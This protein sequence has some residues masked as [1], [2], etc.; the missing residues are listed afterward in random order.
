MPSTNLMLGIDLGTQSTKVLVYD[1]GERATLSVTHAP[2]DIVQKADGTSE[3]DTGGWFAALES[4]ATLPD[5]VR[6]ARDTEEVPSRTRMTAHPDMNRCQFRASS[7]TQ[8][9]QLLSRG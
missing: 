8:L 9:W 1:A 6:R 3:Q 4:C 7:N 5:P 2:H